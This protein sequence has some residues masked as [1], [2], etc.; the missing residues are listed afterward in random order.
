MNR[1]KDPFD[2]NEAEARLLFELM[3]AFIEAGFRRGEALEL[4]VALLTCRARP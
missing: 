3:E 4:A 2:A 1:V